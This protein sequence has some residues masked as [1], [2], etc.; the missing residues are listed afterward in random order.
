MT[1]KIRLQAPFGDLRCQR[2]VTPAQQ[3]LDIIIHYAS[4]GVNADHSPGIPAVQARL[5]SHMIQRIQATKAMPW[6]GS[7]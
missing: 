1:K 6:Y 7:R 3:A 5:I 4:T 2:P